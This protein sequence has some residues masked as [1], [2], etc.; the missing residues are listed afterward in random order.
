MAWAPSYATVDELASYLR[1]DDEVDNVELGLALDAASRAV[2]EH[3]NRQF[4]L[5][6]TPVERFYTARPDYERGYWVVD[7]DDYQTAVGLAVEVDAAAVA[8]FAKEPVNAAGEGRPWTRVAF[9]D[10]SEFTPTGARDEVGVTARWGWTLVPNTVKQA[11]LL[12]ASRIFKRRDAPFGVAGFPELGN[13]MRLLA[14]VDPDV[15]VSLRGY[16]RL[17]S[18]G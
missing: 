13:E 7:V 2:D 6:D 14:K 10:G 1:I 12:Q 4:G 9:T 8:T 17:R 5:I 11:T 15:Q 18:P 16:R 3:T